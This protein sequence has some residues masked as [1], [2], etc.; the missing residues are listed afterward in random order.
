MAAHLMPRQ[1][2]RSLLGI[3]YHIYRATAHEL[4]EWSRGKLARG[5]DPF[6]SELRLMRHAGFAATRVKSLLRRETGKG[7]R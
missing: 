5:S 6:L 2:A 4:A 1:A 3:P 7:R